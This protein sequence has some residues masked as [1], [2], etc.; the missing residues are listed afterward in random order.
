MSKP[1]EQ[2]FQFQHWQ[3]ESSNEKAKPT[4]PTMPVDSPAPTPAPTSEAPSQLK[5]PTV[6]EIE[7]MHDE[8]RRSG[9]EE[10]YAE[11]KAAG[12]QAM[13]EA[14]ET[15]ARR[16]SSLINNLEN[17]LLE[18]EQSVA[19]QLLAVG[20]EIA[21]QVTR[22]TIAANS[23]VLLPIIRE[24]ISALPLHHAH[25][26]FRLNPAD[27]QYIRA[28]LGE[29]FAQMGTQII[30]DKEI[31][32]GGCMLQAGTSEVDATIETRWKRVLESIGAEPQEWLTT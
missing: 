13:R 4:A 6:D 5:L 1:K 15:Q 29:Q 30:E 10:G 26:V 16:F 8:A 22:S 2:L 32:S 21:N 17:A 20:I 24:A 11:G 25:L 23:E 3:T 18:V 27:A 31:S 28:A 14:A 19:E 12:E 9:Y 7:H